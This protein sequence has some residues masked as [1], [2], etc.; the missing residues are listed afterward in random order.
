MEKDPYKITTPLGEFD[1]NSG[2]CN[3]IDKIAE[4]LQRPLGKTLDENIFLLYG[5][6]GTGKTACIQNALIKARQEWD[7]IEKVGKMNKPPCPTNYVT[8]CAPTHTAKGEL[9]RAGNVDSKTLAAV[10]G[11]K[12]EFKNGV[13]VYK[14]TDYKEYEEKKIALPEIFN[15]KTLIVD[16]SSMLGE[17]EHEMIEQRLRERRSPIR[18]I[19]MGDY[20][21]I[22]PVGDKPDSDGFAIDLRKDPQRSIG[23]LKV[24]RTKNRDITEM[25]LA[26]RGAIDFYNDMLDQE[27]PSLQSGLNIHHIIQSDDLKSTENVRYHNSSRDFIHDFI[28]VF[29]QDPDNARNAVIITYNNEK[30][31]NVVAL[32]YG[33]RKQIYG[34]A[35]DHSLFL[36]GEP[37]FIS[38]TIQARCAG[39]GQIELGTNERLIIKTITRKV[40]NIPVG[41]G[42]KAT[43]VK[44]P[45]YEISATDKDNNLVFIDAMD[46]SFSDQLVSANY[47]KI[48]RGYIL[49]DGTV[50]SYANF[51]NLQMAGV[52]NIYHGYL[53]SSHKVQ[54]GTYNHPFVAETNIKKL[55]GMTGNDGQPLVTAKQY[56]QTMYT[57]LSRARD[58][59][60]ILD[61]RSDGLEYNFKKPNKD[62]AAVAA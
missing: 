4:V 56:A 61:T 29:K 23:L 51:K 33:I 36:P 26:Y 19:F 47:N 28:E 3:A 34:S 15:L 52:T 10:L 41:F 48:A 16:E 24:E 62:T 43:V 21:Q 60:Y 46:R 39:G 45:V 57:A 9:M 2:Q 18:I 25:T 42:Y 17:R 31:E 44:V 14:L 54:G 8:F 37:I 53:L 27:V 59:V 5:A 20:C 6:G 1:V 49:N 13:E 58:K 35:A 22:P 50:F 12:P 40:K 11:A 32:T 55:V 38:S 7:A 30:H